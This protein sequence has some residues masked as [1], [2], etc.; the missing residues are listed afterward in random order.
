M[1]LTPAASPATTPMPQSG[2][3]GI[4]LADLSS[5]ILRRLSQLGKEP[6]IS[7][8]D[9]RSRFLN[10]LKDFEGR[11][12]RAGIGA[13]DAANAKYALVAL[14]DEKIL[15]S[16]LKAKDEWLGNPLQL[17]LYDEFNAG[18]LFYEKLE[19]LRHPSRPGQ[20]DAAEVYLLALSFGFKGKLADKKGEERRAILIDNLLSEVLQARHIPA[21]APLAP[22]ALAPGSTSAVARMGLG[23]WWMVPVI[24]TL[25]VAAAFL[26]SSV[27]TASSVSGLVDDLRSQSGKVAEAQGEKTSTTAPAAPVTDEKK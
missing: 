12:A 27:I 23:W 1:T 10:E 14:I 6:S 7:A 11:A 18:E 21:G 13:E 8:D 15:S 25:L 4:T 5:G 2:G 24:G 19:G 16:E 3:G 20:I 17:Q 9:L 22:Q 26:L